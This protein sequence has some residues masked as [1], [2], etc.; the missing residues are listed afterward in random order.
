MAEFPLLHELNFLL[1]LDKRG[2]NDVRIAPFVPIYC[3][4]LM[5]V[6]R[7]RYDRWS[8]SAADDEPRG[9]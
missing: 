1:G 8:G 6:K 2:L 4:V 5:G 3:L 9:G 7:R